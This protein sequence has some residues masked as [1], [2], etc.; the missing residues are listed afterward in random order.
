MENQETESVK[1]SK[2]T[3]DPISQ[4][5]VLSSRQEI[6]GEESNF[7]DDFKKMIDENPNNPL[8]LKK[9]AQFLLQV[10]FFILLC[11]ESNKSFTNYV[12]HVIKH[13]QMPLCLN[14]FQCIAT[15]VSSLGFLNTLTE[16]SLPTII[17]CF[18]FLKH[19]ILGFLGRNVYTLNNSEPLT[20]RGTNIC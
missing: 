13:Q 12:R 2:E 17:I 8:L 1:P 10:R 14:F 6:D 15:Q 20:N 11:P 7:E 9:Y 16:E 4:L 5:S 3:S 19:F 18:I